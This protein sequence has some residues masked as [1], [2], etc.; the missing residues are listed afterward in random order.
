LSSINRYWLGKARLAN[1]EHGN[2]IAG[3]IDRIS[4]RGGRAKKI[5]AAR[6][7]VIND[8]IDK[9]YLIPEPRS[10]GTVYKDYRDLCKKRS[11]GHV[12]YKTFSERLKALLLH[13]VVQKRE[14]QMAAW[15]H[16]PPSTDDPSLPA[17]AKYFMH[18]AQMDEYVFDLATIDPEFGRYLGQIWVV[19][20]LDVY[21]RTVLAIFCSFEE[22]S[23][24]LT[25]LPTLRKCLQRW[26][27][28]PSCILTDRGPGFKEGYAKAAVSMGV[29][30]TWRPAGMARGAPQVERCGGVS[31][32]RIAA[33]LRGHTGI[34]A[35]YRRVSQTHDPALLAVYCLAEHNGLLELY[36]YETYDQLPHGGLN[37]RSPRNM[38][39]MSLKR[40]GERKHLEIQPDSVF[41][42]LSLPGPTRGDGTAKVQEH[43]GI[44]Q[45]GLYYWH[46]K[47]AESEFIGAR[48]QMRWDPC[49]ITH[50]FALVGGKWEECFC[51]MLRELRRLPREQLCLMSVMI[52]RNRKQYKRSAP[53]SVAEIQKLLNGVRKTNA[54]VQEVLQMRESAKSLVLALPPIRLA[55][56]PDATA[57]LSG[58]SIPAGLPSS[59]LKRDTAT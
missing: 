31:N 36:F 57:K 11:V 54:Q 17:K 43:D 30:P 29:R 49:D 23:Y 51:L 7:Q 12:S 58:T 35:K 53:E 42:I 25:T 19:V 15:Q 14:G 33:E 26:K 6:E 40:D 1:A 38:R 28:C 4:H 44:Q 46:G 5:C 47:F 16:T 45:D 9:F 10:K 8:A 55:P 48:V 13:E 21:T 2:P 56:E 3:C 52:R 39:E 34:L 24:A 50:V 20:M 59:Y 27:R 37:N 18:V 32:Q 41:E 22:P